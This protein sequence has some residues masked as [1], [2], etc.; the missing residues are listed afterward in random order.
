MAVVQPIPKTG[1]PILF[2][3][4]RPISV[5]PAMSKVLEK[6]MSIQLR[7]HLEENKILP[8]VQSG[9]REGHSCST[10]L[11]AVLDD[12]LRATDN[13]LVTVLVLLD[14]SKAFDTVNHSIL[15]SILK[16]YGLEKPAVDLFRCYLSD[17]RQY[18]RLSDGDRSDIRSLESGVAQGSVL[19]PVLFSIYTTALTQIFKHSK[20]HL[21]A[22]DTQVYISSKPE[23]LD[24]AI[25]V[26]NDELNKL[27]LMANRHSLV[28]NPTKSKVMLF[29]RQKDIVELE[30]RVIVVVDGYKLPV[31]KEAR[32][33]GLVVDQEIRFRGHITSTLQSAYAKLK[34]LYP[35]R[36]LLSTDVK[37]LL[38][39]SLILSKFNYGDVIYGPCL[40]RIDEQRIQRVQNSCLRFI[41]GIRKYEKISHKLTDA[42]WLN[43]RRRRIGHACLFYYKITKMQKPEYLL[44]KLSYRSDVHNL[45]LRFRG[46]LTP[47]SH[48]TGMFKRSFSYQIVDL[49]NDIPERMKLLTTCSFRKRILGALYEEQLHQIDHNVISCKNTEARSWMTYLR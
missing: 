17:R 49:L 1:N 10:A 46:R 45:N 23:E 30:E 35:S 13:G 8:L 7:Q 14:Y 11:A 33:L 29:G 15:L 31:V 24:Y 43:M 42:G 21:Y 25:S 32:N 4:L 39:D 28:L 12:V 40:L 37:I 22:D 9:Y 47:P 6:I 19:S 2:S 20:I 44:N 5:L 3:D 16:H 34:M 18:V 36:H 48:K 41:Y 38:C 26:L 27:V